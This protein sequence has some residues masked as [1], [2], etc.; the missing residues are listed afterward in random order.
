L[1]WKLYKKWKIVQTYLWKG[2]LQKKLIK[3]EDGWK[4]QN[5]QKT[6]YGAAPWLLI[7]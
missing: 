3:R 7:N 1:P 4:W 6:F 5:Y 2:F